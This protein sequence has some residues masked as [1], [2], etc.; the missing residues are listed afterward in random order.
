MIGVSCTHFANKPLSDWIGPVSRNF[1]HW[2]IF[3]EAEHSVTGR[4]SE[5]SEMVSAAGISCSVHA[6]ICDLNIGALSDRLREASLKETLSTIHSAVELGATTVVVHPGLSSM[7][8]HGTEGIAN[9]YAGRSIR[10]IDAF[11]KEVGADVVIENMPNTPFFLGRTAE[12]LEALVD[13]TDL[14]I[15]FD[16]GHAHTTGQIDAMVDTFGDRI[17]HI[18]IHDNGGQRDEHLTLGEGTIDF[19]HVIGRL[20][21]YRGD[22]IIESRDMDSAI[23]SQS[24]LK[25]M[26]S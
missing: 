7:A 22:W 21:G 13:G 11:S 12:A 6:P 10:R 9:R 18:H 25:K 3:S 17:R 20:S 19:S 16:I 1:R 15:C 24:S 5:I 8:V 26:L 23:A 4:E 14:G 2:E